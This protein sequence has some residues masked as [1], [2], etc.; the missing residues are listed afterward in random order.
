[1]TRDLAGLGLIG[2]LRSRA[3]HWAREVLAGRGT[4]WLLTASVL[5][6]ALPGVLTFHQAGRGWART[7]Q[8]V[9]DGGQS[10]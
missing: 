4:C 8:Q 3:G 1:M 7:R 5:T 6:G 10:S 2:D 9:A